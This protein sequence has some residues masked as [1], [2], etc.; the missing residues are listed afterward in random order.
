MIKWI[1]QH[2]FD[3]IARFRGDVYLDNVPTEPIVS[4]GNLGL[5]ANGRIV[6]NTVSASAGNETTDNDIQITNDDPAFDHMGASINSGTTFTD[7]FEL[8]LNP[9]VQTSISLDSMTLTKETSTNTYGSAVSIEGSQDLHIGQRFRVTQVRYSVANTDK[10]KDTGVDFK[11]NT[12]DIQTGFADSTTSVQDLSSALEIDDTSISSHFTGDSYRFHVTAEDEDSSFPDIS[13]NSFYIRIKHY[14][15]LGGHATS[16][17]ESHA[18]A[19]TLWEALGDGVTGSGLSTRTTTDFT[20]DS[21]I[22]TQDNYTWII[23]PSAWG[24]ISNIKQDDSYGVLDDFLA[25]VAFNIENEF[26]VSVEY[27]LYRSKDDDAFAIG[28]TLTIFF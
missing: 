5:D 12:T 8:I 10:T 15:K 9:Y 17:V 19:K 26:G 16:S 14:F 3:L 1:G 27:K 2:I 28:K 25:P 4:G 11:F 22:D 20:T 24:N 23:Y 6:K 13:S 18:E 21:A 7:V